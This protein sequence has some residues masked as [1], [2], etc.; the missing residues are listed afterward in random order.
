MKVAAILAIGIPLLASCGPSV[1]KLSADDCW[2]LEIGD[3]VEGT[4]TL[5]AYAGEGCI[6]CGAYITNKACP[7]TT[8]FRHGNREVER[9]YDELRKTSPVSASRYIARVVFISGK[10]VPNGATGEPMVWVEQLRAT[11]S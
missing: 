3:R 8:G 2:S 5:H 4:A 7:G 10:V 11:E 9:V 6:E 1:V